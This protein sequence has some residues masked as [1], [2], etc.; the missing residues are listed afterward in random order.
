MSGF[1]QIL[2]CIVT[3]P[4]MQIQHQPL[5]RSIRIQIHHLLPVERWVRLMD[6]AVV[7][8]ADDHLVVCVVVQA[9]DIIIDM[10]R[11]RCRRAE[12]LSDQLPAELA[13]VAV[14]EL[15]V[16]SDLAVQLPDTRQ[17]LIQDEPALEST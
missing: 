13:T 3:S 12:L 10:M 2:L 14:Q 4:Q 15:E 1:C 11:F 16:F 7:V 9:F 17:P 5:L 8:R 6:Y